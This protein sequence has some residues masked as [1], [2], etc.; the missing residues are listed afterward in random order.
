[1]YKYLNI[2][3]GK[4]GYSTEENI[5]NPVINFRVS[6]IWLEENW[7]QVA[8]VELNRYH[9]YAWNPLPTVKT[10]EDSDYIFFESKT[11]VF[12]P[13]A[14]TGQ[15]SQFA[16]GPENQVPDSKEILTSGPAGEENSD[17]AFSSEKN[18]NRSE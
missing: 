3:V 13:F 17:A 15:S 4:N 11:P 1:M 14:I 9:L 10:G 16:S 7:I 8:N 5:G 18:R 6:K 12:S 2:W